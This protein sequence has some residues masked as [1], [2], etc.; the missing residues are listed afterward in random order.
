MMATSLAF[1]SSFSFVAILC[2]GSGVAV[3]G[4]LMLCQ[5]ARLDRVY[6]RAMASLNLGWAAKSVLSLCSLSLL[7][8]VA[9]WLL[10]AVDPAKYLSPGTAAFV[11]SA[12][13]L[14]MPVYAVVMPTS[15][16]KGQGTQVGEGSAT[17]REARQAA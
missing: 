16:A 10:G 5:R 14:G 12:L 4:T 9:T 6:D 8:M 1:S 2:G 11:Y 17:D 15:R 7:T 3:F 13:M